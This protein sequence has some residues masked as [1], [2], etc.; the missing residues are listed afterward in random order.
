VSPLQGILAE[1][2]D[3]VEIRYEL[4]SLTYKMVPLL[5]AQMVHPEMDSSAVGLKAE[6]FANED[7]SGAPVF[8]RTYQKFSLM[9]MDD[10]PPGIEP[11]NF[12]MRFSGTLTA[13][14][15]GMYTFSL[16]SAGLSR[17]Y[18][19][20]QEVVDNWTNP[21]P[22][23]TF[24]G[25]GSTEVSALYPMTEG[26]T[27][28]LRLDFSTRGS[29]FMAA[30]RLGC[31][32]PIPE[33]AVE[34]A[35]RLAAESDVAVV[36][37]GL[38]GEWESEGF[39]RPN[40]DL[41]AEQNELIARVAAA[42]P[43]TVVVLNTGSPITMPWLENIAAV[44][45]AWYPG[46]ECGNAIADV[47]FGRVNPAGRLTQTY[48]KRLE[49]NPTYINYPGENGKVYYGEGLFVGYRYYDKKQIEPLFPFGYGLSYTTF[50]YSNL[51]IGAQYFDSADHIPVSVDV[52]NTGSRAGHE[53]VQLYVTDIASR[54]ARPEKEL[55]A[56]AKVYLEPG[57]T[58]TVTFTLDHKA[59]SY[60]DP[61]EPGWVA[62]A[63]LFEVLVGSSS[64]DIRAVGQFELTQTVVT[65]AQRSSGLTTRSALRELLANS[66]AKAVVLAHIPDLVDHP[67]L[68]AALDFSLEQIASFVPEMLTPEL[69]KAVDAELAGTN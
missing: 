54:L 49:D 23:E 33:D 26:Q 4:G 52:T 67:Q 68:N 37:A 51:T 5:E 58:K 62:E 17:L 53:V 64:R 59:L 7:L 25:M 13:E 56:F 11:V 12:S 10:L 40:M 46:Q 34:R 65:S 60:Y 38:G 3:A 66:R 31:L 16:V 42:N 35:A 44:L 14:A 2:G 24:F 45:Q 48:P 55:K 19:D 39:D 43:N 20:D 36:F 50:Q 9:W 32:P 28:R 30:L 61:A 8:T 15:T 22:G 69:L 29:Q 47:L 63:G 41:P 21:Q 6:F 1:A 57:E 18:I 27:Y